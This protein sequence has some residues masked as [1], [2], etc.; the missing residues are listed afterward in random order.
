MSMLYKF[1]KK[2]RIFRQKQGPKV[3]IYVY[4]F[5]NDGNDFLKTIIVPRGS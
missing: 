3:R 4:I 2:L 1:F 5:E